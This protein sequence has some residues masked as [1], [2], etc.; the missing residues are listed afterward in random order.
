MTISV[1]PIGTLVHIGTPDD[2]ITA[3]VQ[4]V[5]VRGLAHGV[6][7]ECVW[8]DG[9]ARTSGWLDESEVKATDKK[10]VKV[11]IG[12]TAEAK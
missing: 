12:F 7:Y 11:Q 2:P 3:V 6:Q 4:Q 5:C 9:K 8:W 1:F 10:P